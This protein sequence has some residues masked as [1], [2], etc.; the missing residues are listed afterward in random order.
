MTIIDSFNRDCLAIPLERT[1]KASQRIGA[2]DFGKAEVK[3]H[4]QFALETLV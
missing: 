4:M 3:S 2:N 1:E